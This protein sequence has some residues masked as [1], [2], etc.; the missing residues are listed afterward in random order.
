MR[1][2]FRENDPRRKEAREGSSQSTI[3]V[4]KGIR[5]GPYEVDFIV[6]GRTIIEVDGYSHV[7]PE[8]A[9]IDREKEI[10]LRE[11]G[12]HVIRVL[13]DQTKDAHSMR[14]LVKTLAKPKPMKHNKPMAYRPFAELKE[15]LDLGEV[16]RDKTGREEMLEWL[17]RYEDRIPASK[18]G[19]D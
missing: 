11:K 10:Y 9:R 14:K 12:F 1:G 15:H 6:H 16:Q 8:K 13:S 18:D 2:W 4:S 17:N 3:R 7:L 5:V 19:E